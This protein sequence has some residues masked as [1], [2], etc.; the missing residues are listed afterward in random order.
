MSG[1]KHVIQ[2]KNQLH[3]LNAHFGR[4]FHIQDEKSTAHFG[5]SFHTQD[6]I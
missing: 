3:M 4:I 5:H 2:M 6:E 1:R